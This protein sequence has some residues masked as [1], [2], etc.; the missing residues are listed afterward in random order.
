MGSASE[1]R[2][3]RT[4]WLLSIVIAVLS[5]I[6]DAFGIWFLIKDYEVVHSCK[7]SNRDVHVVWPTNLWV[8]V[9]LSVGL[10]IIFIIGLF[11]VPFRKSVDAIQKQLNRTSKRRPARDEIDGRPKLKYGYMPS[12]PDWLLLAHGTALIIGSVLLG[13]L[14]FCG[15]VELFL[16]RPWCAD[17]KTAF[18]E[19]DLWHFGRVTFFMQ[20][21]F[22]VVFF[23]WG[24][25]YWMMPFLFEL[26]EPEAS[27]YGT[28]PDRHGNT[29]V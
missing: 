3:G 22:S 19:L 1:S 13:I 7:A 16:A 6:Y 28:I 25:C 18:E 8:Y 5:L 12:L 11:V 24:L 20:V 27:S 17:T 29:G 15:Y 4:A 2:A 21:I 10:S 26:N 9:L 14:A 23:L